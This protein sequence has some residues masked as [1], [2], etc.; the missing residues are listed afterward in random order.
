ML[1]A[2]GFDQLIRRFLLIRHLPARRARLNGDEDDFSLW[3]FFVNQ[4]GEALEIL[5]HLLGSLAGSDVIVACIED[6]D[7]WFRLDDDARSEMRR[8]SDLR[9]AEAAIDRV[10]VGKGFLQVPKS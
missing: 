8:V 1:L 4:L 2:V 10:Q 3:Q 9:A 5:G 6:N 7:P